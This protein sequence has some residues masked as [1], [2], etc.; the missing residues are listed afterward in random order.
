M[1]VDDEELVREMTCEFLG[2]MGHSYKFF[3][4]GTKAKDYYEK[5]FENIDI[6]IL[7]MAMPKMYGKQLFE[8][9]QRINPS[10]KVIIATGHSIDG[11]VREFLTKGVAALIQKPFTFNTLATAI[12]DTFKQTITTN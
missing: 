11:Q 10:A 2:E 1:V 4:D 8:E 7:D 6:V 9:I 12:A 5:N 3:A